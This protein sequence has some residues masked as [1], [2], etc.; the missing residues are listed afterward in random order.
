MVR[1]ATFGALFAT[2]Y[3]AL[4]RVQT[5]LEA[6]DAKREQAE[7]KKKMERLTRVKH[8]QVVKELREKGM[9]PA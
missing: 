3:F 9:A 6:T 1:F 8:K 7:E 4:S 5:V 2:A